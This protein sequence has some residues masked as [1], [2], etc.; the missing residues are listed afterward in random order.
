MQSIESLQTKDSYKLHNGS[1]TADRG[2]AKRAKM[3]LDMEVAREYLNCAPSFASK[4]TQWFEGEDYPNPAAIAFEKL[5][6][7]VAATCMEST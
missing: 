4:L 2:F 1:D 3:I 5:N 6:I 7:S